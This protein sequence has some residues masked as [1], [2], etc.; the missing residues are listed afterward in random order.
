M[1]QRDQAAGGVVRSHQPRSWLRK[2]THSPALAH[3]R[4]LLDVEPD[5]F[6]FRQ[7]DFRRKHP[8]RDG[9][10]V[11]E[12]VATHCLV[13]RQRPVS[14]AHQAPE[15]APDP[16]PIAQVPRDRAQVC[17]AAASD[18]DASDRVRASLKVEQRGGVDLHLARGGPRGLAFARERVSPLAL[19]LHRRVRRRLLKDATREGRQRGFDIGGYDGARVAHRLRLRLGVVCLG[20]EAEMDVGDV[21]L[22]QLQGELG[23]TGR[24]LEEDR[25]HAGRKRV[26]RAGVTHTTGPGEAPQPVHDCEGSLAGAFVEVENPGP[27]SRSVSAGTR[28]QGWPPWQPTVPTSWPPPSPF[29]SRRRRPGCGLHPRTKHTG[30]RRPPHRGCGR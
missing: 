17:T 2:H 28:W 27:K 30:R 7:Y 8:I 15:V 13:E 19:H 16:K 25:Q 9:F 20:H 22:R 1:A 12:L 5:S 10:G 14:R 21:R 23:K 6:H 3:L 11:R 26:E 29:R 24:R 4:L 18:L